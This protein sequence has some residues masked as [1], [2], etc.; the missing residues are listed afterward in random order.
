M[1]SRRPTILTLVAI[2]AAMLCSASVASAAAGE[3]RSEIG[4][5][6][7]R[8]ATAH[9]NAVIVEGSATTY[10]VYTLRS[11]RGYR[12]VLAYT[13]SDKSETVTAELLETING[14]QR[15]TMLIDVDGDGKLDS[16]FAANGPTVEDAFLLIKNGRGIRQPASRFQWIYDSLIDDLKREVPLEAAQR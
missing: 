1:S 14:I 2:G 8:L 12:A 16:S 5:R 7:K 11:P 3:L 10:Y 4:A 9:S 13:V 15:V 6:I